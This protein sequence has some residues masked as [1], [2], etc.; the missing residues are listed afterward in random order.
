M[1][2]T[3]I[4]S[5]YKFWEPGM[6]L[7]GDVTFNVNQVEAFSPTQK[8]DTLAALE[9]LYNGSTQGPN[10]AQFLLER[11][12]DGSDFWLFNT[13]AFQ[14]SFSEPGEKISVFNFGDTSQKYMGFDGRFH[15]LTLER[16]LI[17]E[18]FHAIDWTEDLID[19]DTESS[20]GNEKRNY[21]HADFN[22]LGE[23]VEKT[24]QIMIDM[25]EP[26]EAGRAGYDAIFTG[27]DQSKDYAPWTDIDLAYGDHP[28]LNQTPN[29]LLTADRS[30]DSDDLLFGFD[31]D[32]TIKSGAGNDYLYG[33]MGNDRLFGG[34]GIDLLHGG[35]RTNTIDLDGIDI[36]DYSEG[37]HFTTLPSGITIN[38][39]LGGPL[40]DGKKPIVVADDGY[41]S[42]DYLYSIEKIIGTLQD[43]TVTVLGGD[44]LFQ[45]SN[46]ALSQ[47]ILPFGSALTIDGGASEDT[48]DFTNYTGSVN[49]SELDPANATVGDVSFKNFEIVEDSDGNGQ[50][51][52]GAASIA[53]S[54]LASAYSFVTGVHTI[55]G[56]GGDDILVVGPS[57]Q[58]ID[59]GAGN[60]LVVAIGSNNATLDGGADDD[61][62]ISLG[63]ANNLLF[64]GGGKD[65]LF[66]YSPGARLTGGSEADTFYYSNNVLIKE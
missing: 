7:P 23:T 1:S 22:H 12:V 8:A 43:D 42:P 10:S 2:W 59:G 21:N 48:L 6:P 52:Q 41:G 32:D 20:Y 50:V 5:K 53:A 3:D 62:I 56:N 31:G 49:I 25:G 13:T 30:D 16:L 65:H 29:T 18:F 37:D 54:L 46:Y 61:I 33:G 9:A 63:G 58:K 35:D 47:G 64:G 28:N 55:Y 60:D 38:F 36:A 4:E 57:G 45:A 51:G 17:H 14:S 44:E 15:E 27:L 66:A 24:N 11:G 34:S 40:L 19:P 26:A 39:D